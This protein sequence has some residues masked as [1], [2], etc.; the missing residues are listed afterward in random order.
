MVRLIDAGDGRKL[1]VE[2][3]GAPDGMPVFLLHGTPG[4]RSGPRPRD[5]VLHRLGVRLISYDRPGYGR[6]DRQP[7]R[8]VADAARDV[9]TI[10]TALGV[11]RFGV[12][13]RSGGGPHALACAARLRRRV[14]RVAALVSLAPGDA[15]GLDWYG[16]MNDSNRR[17]YRTTDDDV[18][19]LAADLIDRAKQIQEDPDSLV[20]RLLPELERADRR[21][22]EDVGLRRLLGQTYREAVRLGADGWI[23]D[24]LAFRRDWGF[25]LPAIR[26]P[27]LLWHGAEDMFSPVGHTRW[28][29]ER[30]PGALLRVE[31]GL[32][33]FGAVEILPRILAWIAEPAASRPEAAGLRTAADPGRAAASGL[34]AG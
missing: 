11:E 33:H 9:E 13:G 20:R 7:G 23:D 17:E 22:V 6:S 15:D 5:I 31:P 3:W 16:G 18:D 2:T 19:F 29:A 14:V 1:A 4:S 32:A 34:P 21:V 8:T 27:V 25:E 10:A 28:L 30:I 24:V 12:V 26:V